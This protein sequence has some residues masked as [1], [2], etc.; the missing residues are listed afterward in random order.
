MYVARYHTYANFHVMARATNRVANPPATTKTIC[1]PEHQYTHALLFI[2][3]SDMP[4]KL[5]RH[6]PNIGRPTEKRGP[7]TYAHTHMPDRAG[8]IG[9]PLLN[10]SQNPSKGAL[11]FVCCA[12]CVGSQLARVP[13]AQRE[14]FWE[15]FRTRHRRQHKV[16]SHDGR[17]TTTT[18]ERERRNLRR[19]ERDDEIDNVKY[20]E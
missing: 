12:V 3:I 2:G 4:P 8:Q 6:R 1:D 13:N 14:T 5:C 15:W 7:I 19:T 16:V 18:T 11:F 17:Q 10:W 20:A 9:D